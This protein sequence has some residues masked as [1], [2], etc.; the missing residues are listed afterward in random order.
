MSVPKDGALD[1][2]LQTLIFKA[3]STSQFLSFIA[4][5]T[6]SGEPPIALPDGQAVA[7]E[8]LLI[9]GNG[10]GLE[11]LAVESPALSRARPASGPKDR[12]LQE[13]RV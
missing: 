9:T 10:L 5:G 12:N 13:T 11:T 8:A 3:T 2:N 1:W 6:S 7:Q 4:V